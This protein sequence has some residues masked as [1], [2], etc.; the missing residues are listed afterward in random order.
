[1]SGS[2]NATG[3]GSL[4]QIVSSTNVVKQTINQLTAETSSG[5]VSSDFAGLGAGAPIVLDLGPQLAATAQVQSNATAAGTIQSAAQTALGQIES[6]ASNFA[7]QAATLVG[8]QGTVGT[9][10]ASAQDALTQVATLLDTKVGDVYVFAG[11]DSANPP[12]PDPQ[13]IT[14]SAFATAIQAAVAGLT[15]N[16]QAA[17]SA[18]TLAIA[19]PGGTSPFSATLEAAGQ[20]SQV[21]LGGGDYLRLAPL[22]NT[23]SDAASAGVGTTSTGS[24]TRDILRGLAT[25]GALTQAQASD[26]NFIPLVQDTMTSLNG[27]VSAINTDIG[28][29]GDRQD[30]VSAAGTAASDTGTALKSQLSSVQDADLA[31]VAVQLSDAQTQLQASYQLISNLSTLSLAKFLPA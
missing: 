28:A 24:Y 5:Y 30:Q 22:A 6:I 2:V 1:M 9:I 4:D 11:Q 19:S 12:V 3:Y 21:D 23:N 26:P 10:A 16:G 25:I 17:T 20:Q 14:S 31:Q 29:L 18:A 7:A 27:A 8:T 13:G 15:T